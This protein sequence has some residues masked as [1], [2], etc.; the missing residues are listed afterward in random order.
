MIVKRN[1]NTGVIK[2]IK[3]QLISRY[4][5]ICGKI[6]SQ[7]GN[8]DS[9]ESDSDDSG[10]SLEPYDG[11]TGDFDMSQVLICHRFQMAH[12]Y[13]YNCKYLNVKF[14]KYNAY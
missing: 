10:E 8:A 12:R 6:G 13:T 5:C 4:A 7:C 2:E 9:S 1:W 11:F 14:I 3:M